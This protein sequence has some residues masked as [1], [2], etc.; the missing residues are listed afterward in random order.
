MFQTNLITLV[1]FYTINFKKNPLV[2]LIL[3]IETIPR[4]TIDEV[5]EEAVV[6]KV[7]AIYKV[8]A[9]REETRDGKDKE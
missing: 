5:V 2:F 7:K 9:R 8:G 1:L 4:P 3:D 6:K